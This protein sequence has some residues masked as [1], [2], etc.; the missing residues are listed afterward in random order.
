[1]L[2]ISRFFALLLLAGA[3]WQAWLFPVFSLP[4][5]AGL[6]LYFLAMTRE[7]RLWL[8]V[9][10]P[11]AA[12]LSLGYWSGRYFID[13]FDLLVVVTLAGGLWS[14]LPWWRYLQRGPA[15]MMLGVF[16]AWQLLVT[17]N[18]LF[19]LTAVEGG[20]WEDY[21]SSTNALREAK[22]LIWA[23][24]LLPMLAQLQHTRLPARWVVGGMVLALL[25]LVLTIVWERHLY[26]GVLNF[27]SQ[28]RVS[29]WFFDMHTGGAA[30]D[31]MLAL[32]FPFAF[33]VLLWW[34][35]RLTWLAFV[36]LVMLGMYALV[37]TYSRA[38]YP[39]VALI[40]GILLLGLL[41]LPGKGRSRH[42]K[43]WV[44]LAGSL[45]VLFVLPLLSGAA[46]LDR[47]KTTY[48][49]LQTRLTHWDDAINLVTGRAEPWIGIGKGHFPERYQLA[50]QFDGTPLPTILLQRGDVEHSVRFSPSNEHGQM[51]LRQRI[52]PVAGQRYQLT[53]L[54]RPSGEQRER[55]II[56]FCERH[57]LSVRG[58]CDWVTV[59]IQNGTEGFREYSVPVGINSL[60][61]GSLLDRSPVDLAILNRGFKQGIEIASVRL[62]DARGNELLRNGDFAAGMDHW[63]M[64]DGDH[65]RW[66][67]KNVFVHVYVESGV[68][69]LVLFVLLS[70]VVVSRSWRLHRSGD[71]LGILLFAAYA[72][73]LAV[74]LFDSLF[75]APRITLLVFMLAGAAI[76]WQPQAVHVALPK[77]QLPFRL[78]LPHPAFLLIPAVVLMGLALVYQ[79]LAR[80]RLSV[81]QLV[82]DYARMLQLDG[83]WLMKQVSQG[84]AARPLP[85]HADTAYRV[86]GDVPQNPQARACESGALLWRAVCW[87]TARNDQAARA[88]IEQLFALPDQRPKTVTHYGNAWQLVVVYDLL[89]DHPAFDGRQ[90]FQMQ[91][92]F[93]SVLREYLLLLDGEGPALWHGRATLAAQAMLLASVMDD[94]L[95]GVKPD[96]VAERQSLRGRA[97]AHYLQLI[98]SLEISGGWPEGYNYW[99]NERGFLIALSGLAF[100]NSFA[101]S[102]A[103]DRVLRA[104][105]RLGEWHIHTTRPDMRAAK[106]GDEGPRI[107]LRHDTQRIV[108][109]L[110]MTTQAPQ[111]R[112]FS[113]RI[114]A[115]FRKRS[116]FRD[117]L[118][119]VGLLPNELADWKGK[120]DAQLQAMPTSDWFGRNGMNMFY[121]RSGWDKQ[122][123][124]LSFRAGQSL[125]H[126]GHYD[127]G[128][129]TLFKGAP[130]A[131]TGATYRDF[132]AP[133][134]L[135]YGIRT[136]SK[137]SLLVLRPGETVKVRR[138]NKNV[139]DGGQRPTLPT[140]SNL[141]SVAEWRENLDAGLHLRAADVSYY[142]HE[143][144]QFTYVEV[145]LT[146]AYNNPKHDEGGQ[147][148]KVNK[149]VRR[150]LYLNQLDRVLV[151]DRIDA[152]D[153]RYRAR[154]L[155][156]SQVG[157][158]EEPVQV[159]RG[160]PNNGVVKMAGNQL[161][162]KHRDSY[163]QVHSLLPEQ[164]ELIMVGGRD[165]RFL[166]DIDGDAATLDG[167]QMGQNSRITEWF[168]PALWR[169]EIGDPT[170]SAKQEFLTLLSPS[171]NAYQPTPQARVLRREDDLLVV[172]IDQE[173]LVLTDRPAGEITL[174]LGYEL[175]NIRILGLPS[176]A[177]IRF[178]MDGEEYLGA[179]WE[180]VRGEIKLNWM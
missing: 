7:P 70:A 63:F 86:W 175:A 127:A 75:D 59:N 72:G 28:Y 26:T 162:F 108:D 174:N 103:R 117:Y 125:S 112:E 151:H 170:Q 133:H 128:H 22:G 139:A 39:A 1:M 99:V 19:P 38:N 160:K 146:P 145:D 152:V 69:G 54:A 66:H 60:G 138:S 82:Y 159:L 137:N 4:L 51:V 76:V 74:G 43:H 27:A 9:L 119:M 101:D 115:H 130:L 47:F 172:R 65:L 31:A 73:V 136:V 15:L 2:L 179:S 37:V 104:M 110:Y 134:R 34:R 45:A 116:Y 89:R 55:L 11:A 42:N 56:E 18:G 131:V 84:P 25:A 62:R 88:A 178:E 64:S 161:H 180:G 71:P 109:L 163:L 96:E 79:G 165:H 48:E 150:L 106:I 92:R 24:L 126:H 53:L 32:S 13:E 94:D 58:E 166:T 41:T 168:E 16:V 90:Q 173:V 124:F 157:A 123:T 155:L 169:L 87:A 91:Q 81:K 57:V 3:L 144:G 20:N 140:G 68:I 29:G 78:R 167:E 107:D 100:S 46:V 36:P 12:A 14:A 177:L 21:F 158:E 83:D 61:Q 142:H 154:F 50:R 148:G 105:L 97:Y 40:F 121:M 52:Q 67:I 5:V 93:A 164:P 176:R 141:D 122:A 171:L 153:P 95:P 129:F 143:P 118:W 156:Q 120:S 23:M 30:V 102:P 10:P 132:W 114:S 77:L 113:Q 44:W 111:L 98:E 147:G 85:P 33:G 17:Y 135:N 6:T 149:V 8:L 49:D 80:D 35:S